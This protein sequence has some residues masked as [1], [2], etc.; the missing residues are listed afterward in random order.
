LFLPSVRSVVVSFLV[1]LSL[2][3]ASVPLSRALRPAPFRSPIQTTAVQPEAADSSPATAKVTRFVGVVLPSEAVDVTANI[4]GRIDAIRVRTGDRVRRGSVIAV[5]DTGTIRADMTIAE[6]ELKTAEAD[7]Q[8][9][10]IELAQARSRVSRIASLRDEQLV[11]AEKLEDIRY[12]EQ[13]ASAR[14]SAAE[15]AV[16]EKRALVE[17]RTTLLANVQ[18]KAPIDGT[19]AVRYV[20]RGW[21]VGRATPIVRLVRTAPLKIRFAIPSRESHLLYV[22]LPISALV[23]DIGVTL[24][25]YVETVAPEIDSASQMLLVEAGIEKTSEKEG[26]MFAGRTATVTVPV[27]TGPLQSRPGTTPSRSR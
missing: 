15:N 5:L 18:V 10:T 24:R 7:K 16:A 25:G 11:S 21:P 9:S 1:L 13:I 3:L 2:W 20:D 14:M 6:A 17:Q 22:G 4:D 26:V 27:A 8:R 23:E 12:E 19:V